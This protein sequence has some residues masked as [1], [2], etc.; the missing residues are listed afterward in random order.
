MCPYCW[1]ATFIVGHAVADH[2]DVIVSICGLEVLNYL[3]F[4]A[5]FGR[6]FFLVK[7]GIF[8]YFVLSQSE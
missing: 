6:E 1:W 5:R 8:A 7:A 3:A 4:A 2:H